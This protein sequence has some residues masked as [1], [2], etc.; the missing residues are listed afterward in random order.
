MLDVSCIYVNYNSATF[1]VAAIQSLIK[2]TKNTVTYEIVVVD[3]G[4]E[5]ENYQLLKTSLEHLKI[6]Y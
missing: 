1:T 4:S 2:K 3:N 5:Y 6:P